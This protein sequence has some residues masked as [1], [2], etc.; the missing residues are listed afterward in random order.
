MVSDTGVPVGLLRALLADYA[1]FIDYVKLGIGSAYVT[2][3][4]KEKLAVYAE[5]GIPVYFGGTLFEKF[6]HQGKFDQYLD[7]LRGLGISHLEISNGTT[8]LS[9]D[10]RVALVERVKGEFTVFSEVGC[11]DKNFIMPPSQWI[12][13]INTLMAAGSTFVITEG[14][15]SGTAGIYRSS[16]EIRTGLVSDIIKSCDASR[17]IFEAPNGPAQM[18]F[19]GLLGADVNIGNV[20]PSEVLVLE[21]ERCGLRSETFFIG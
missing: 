12:E 17:V 2:P 19:I 4:L 15:D 3:N 18:F 6:Q 9:L 10:A 7:Y 13:E 8:D 1:C 21:A 14:R 11:K 16:G 20:P 5:Y